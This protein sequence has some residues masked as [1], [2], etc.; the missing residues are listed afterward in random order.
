MNGAPNHPRFGEKETGAC[1]PKTGDF[2][3]QTGLGEPA[4][5]EG[6]RRFF[7]EKAPKNGRLFWP[8]YGFTIIWI[9]C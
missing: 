8:F 6:A 4:K 2:G 5:K 7:L 3:P 1:C 9:L